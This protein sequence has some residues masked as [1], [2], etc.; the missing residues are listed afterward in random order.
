MKD[1]LT[2]MRIIYR[3]STIE[4]M[5]QRIKSMIWNRRKQQQ[6]KQSEQTKRKKYPKT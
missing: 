5:T 2:E 4:E 6:Q 3:E 1:A